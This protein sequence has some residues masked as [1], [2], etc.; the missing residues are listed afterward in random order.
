MKRLTETDMKE[1]NKKRFEEM[2]YIQR[3]CFGY[4]CLKDD[5]PCTRTMV[6]DLKSSSIII[7]FRFLVFLVFRF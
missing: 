4:K 3:V 5:D 6:Y 1:N 7:Y 2:K